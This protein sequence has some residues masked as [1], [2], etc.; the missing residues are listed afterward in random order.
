[1][2]RKHTAFLP[3][4]LTAFLLLPLIIGIA[5]ANDTFVQESAGNLQFVQNYSV[6]VKS[7][8]LI[9]GPPIKS[10]E[11]SVTYLIPVHVEYQLENITESAVKATIGFPLSA[12]NLNEYLWNKH[13]SYLSGSASSC[14][15][16]PKMTLSVDGLPISSGNWD[17]VF[18]LDGRG[19][20][21]TKQDLDLSAR[22]RALIGLVGDP[23]IKF[24]R[25]DPDFAVAAKDLCRRLDGEYRSPEC[26]SFSR[27]LVHRTFVW[28]YEFLPK[29]R[30]KVVH[31]YTVRASWNLDPQ[32]KFPYDVFCLD[33]PG[34]SQAWLKYKSD[35]INKQQGFKNEFYTEY[36][37]KTGALW[38]TPIEDFELVIRRSSA[39]QVVATCFAGLSKT[40]TLEFKA[41]RT[42][43]RPQENLRVMYFPRVIK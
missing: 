21:D 8:R 6:A 9:I 5:P 15:K 37:L 4:G 17:F 42:N 13:L 25:E 24:Y 32:E 3:M 7:E 22:V 41:H 14:V 23:E 2:N 10:A 34:V 29:R 16:E 31:D 36:V 38:A 27:L 28:Q 35:V 40:G 12:C 20:A 30:T 26:P 43:Y 18:L 19:L 33:D 39:D 11:D 1:M